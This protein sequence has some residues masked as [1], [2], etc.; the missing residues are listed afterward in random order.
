MASA[1][2]QTIP[3]DVVL[4]DDHSTDPGTLAALKELAELPTVTLLRH[5][6]NQGVAAAIN[7]GFASTHAPYLLMVGSDDVVEPTFAA[8]ASEILDAQ[9][10]VS[11]VVSD[12]QRFGAASHVDVASSVPN[13]VRDML[14]HNVI[15]GASVCRRADWETVGGYA[16]LRWGEDYEYWIR[17]LSLGGTCVRIPSVQYHYRIHPGQATETLSQEEKLADRLEVIARNRD[18]WADNLDVIMARLWE[19]EEALAYFK[20]RYG[21]LNDVKSRAVSIARGLR[22][23]LNP[24]K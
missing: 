5:E 24:A 22:R 4:V 3:V 7:T 9:S 6:S 16:P 14:F 21:P 13:G 10:E 18:V 2:A 12:I 11:I 20:R 17:V 23:R 19:Q 15:S 8:L 1:V